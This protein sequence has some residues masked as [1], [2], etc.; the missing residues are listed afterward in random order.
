MRELAENATGC[1]AGLLDRATARLQS[2]LPGGAA[3]EANIQEFAKL[4]EE[5]EKAAEKC[6]R[7]YNLA[8]R[9]VQLALEARKEGNLTQRMKH[10]P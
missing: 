4:T 9:D 6:T 5:K 10:E 1:H 3:V 8:D 7:I 2:R